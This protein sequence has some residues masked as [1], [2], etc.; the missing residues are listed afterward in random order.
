VNGAGDLIFKYKSPL[1]ETVIGEVASSAAC[2]EACYGSLTVCKSFNYQLDTRNCVINNFKRSEPWTSFTPDANFEHYNFLRL[3][4]PPSTKEAVCTHVDKPGVGQSSGES[5]NTQILVVAECKSLVGSKCRK[6][7][8]CVFNPVVSDGWNSEQDGTWYKQAGEKLV[9]HTSVN[10]QYERGQV[11]NQQACARICYRDATVC[12]SFNYRVSDG[13]CQI[14]SK[15]SQL[16]VDGDKKVIMVAD[17][18]AEY[19]ELISIS[20]EPL[21]TESVCTHQAAWKGDVEKARSCRHKTIRE[22]LHPS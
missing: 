3:T 17:P 12:Q 21:T 18:D 7:S 22:C 20:Q 2:A 6:D 10:L 5:Q 1:V 11:A 14:N 15:N 8:R 16:P 13:N 19:W 4:Q 9:T